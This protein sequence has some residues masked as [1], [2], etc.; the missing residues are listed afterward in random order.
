MI[1]VA[2]K[3]QRVAIVHDLSTLP[4]FHLNK[5]EVI[6][7]ALSLMG[8]PKQADEHAFGGRLNPIRGRKSNNKREKFEKCE[9]EK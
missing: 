3:D 8:Q 7:I 5:G 4:N 2:D 9:R 6:N 1:Q